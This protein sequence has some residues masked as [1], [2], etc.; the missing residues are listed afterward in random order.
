MKPFLTTIFMAVLT[1][2][3]YSQN[4]LVADNNPG[5]PTGSHVYATLQA[6][7][8][9]AVPGDIIHVIP[10]AQDYDGTGTVTVATDSLSIYGI[11]FLPDK[12]G[13]LTAEIY[14][15]NLNADALRVSGI[16]I[17]DYVTISSDNQ[18]YSGITIENSYVG[19]VNTSGSAA[20]SN[21]LIRGCIINR[22]NQVSAVSLEFT[23][24]VSNSV[25]S[26]CILEHYGTGTNYE[27][28]TA[29]NGTIIK[30]C[31]FYGHGNSS[32]GTLQN[33]TV[34]NSIFYGSL[35]TA[36]SASNNVF[37]H[38]TAVLNTDGSN[39]D[40]SGY[41]GTG[42]INTTTASTIFADANI[43]TGA[44]NWAYTW[45]PAVNHADLLNAGT[46]GTDI[47][48][49][50]GTIPYS[51]TGTTLPLIKRLLIPEVIKQGDNLDATIEAQGF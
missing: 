9:A 18:P 25:I 48:V 45:D 43:V 47:G 11:G 32:F 46:D 30:N 50:G 4:I 36:V 6:A 1:S 34:S 51:T 22:A 15:I 8:D 14:R 21:I 3:G 49:M 37:N 13:P 10:S 31:I 2:I 27:M 28:I 23:D 24:M 12:D 5:A 26:N 19:E 41:T 44:T 35:P 20:L 29:Y 7:V 16:R 39:Y 42:N 33:C 40:M 17:A 38:C